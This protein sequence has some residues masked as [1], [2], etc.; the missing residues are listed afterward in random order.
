MV[1]PE[2]L[3]RVEAP[4]VPRHVMHQGIGEKWT[5]LSTECSDTEGQDF[6]RHERAGTP[7]GDDDF[8]TKLESALGRSMCRQED[9]GKRSTNDPAK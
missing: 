6:R 4:G 1:S 8:L 3:A 5:I 2:F 7:S 9:S